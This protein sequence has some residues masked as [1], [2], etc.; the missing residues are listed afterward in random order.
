MSKFTQGKVGS[1]TFNPYL[2]YLFAKYPEVLQFTRQPVNSNPEVLY[3]S[4]SLWKV[5][6]HWC[7]LSLDNIFAY[8][9]ILFR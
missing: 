1:N 4:V 3:G 2:V 7:Y 6:K 5:G 9:M 8:C